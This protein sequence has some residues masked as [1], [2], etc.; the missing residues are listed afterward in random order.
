MTA[1]W[2][3]PSTTLPGK[4]YIKDWIPPPVSKENVRWAQLRTIE[5]AKLDDPDPKIVQDLV[6]LTKQAIRDD[7]F[8]FLTDYGIS[9]EQVRNLLPHIVPMKEAD[10]QLHRQFSIANYLHQNIWKEDQQRREH[11]FK[12]DFRS[13]PDCPQ[14]TGIPTIQVHLQ[15]GSRLLAGV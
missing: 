12:Y 13:N 15:V 3:S 11:G 1:S 9:L 4:P 2:I 7:G 5:L 6:N 10:S 14:C 8:I